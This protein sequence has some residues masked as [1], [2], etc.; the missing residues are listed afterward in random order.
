MRAPGKGRLRRK[1]LEEINFLRKSSAK[2]AQHFSRYV[3]LNV[4]PHRASLKNMPG[5]VGIEP[6]T[7]GILVPTVPGIFFKLALCGYTFRVTYHKHHI[8][9]STQHQHRNN[10]RADGAMHRARVLIPPDYLHP[11]KQKH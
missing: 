7:F 1:A 3:T 8:H 10:P 6:T 5:T 11:G 2:S 9:L 4:Y